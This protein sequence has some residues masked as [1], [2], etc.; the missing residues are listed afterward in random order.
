LLFFGRK[1]KILT[2][3]LEPK[4]SVTVS[5][6]RDREDFEP[7]DGDYKSRV[8]IKTRNEFS[9]QP[10]FQI[11]KLMSSD[12]LYA[13]EQEIQVKIPLSKKHSSCL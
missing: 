9:N 1:E 7:R 3:Q 6:C 12:I 5:I 11:D 13:V 2:N 8:I 10:I 4:Q